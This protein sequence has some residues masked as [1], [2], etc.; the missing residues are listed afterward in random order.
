MCSN[1]F[2]EKRQSFK[3]IAY[4]LLVQLRKDEHRGVRKAVLPIPPSIWLNLSLKF[5]S[6]HET[7]LVAHT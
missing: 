7:N 5:L 2:Y 6:E 4:M 3:L 1:N